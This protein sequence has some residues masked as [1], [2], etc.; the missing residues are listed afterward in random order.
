MVR[1]NPRETGID[2]QAVVMEEVPS[3]F[4]TLWSIGQVAEYLA[5]STKTLYGWRCR[6]YGPPSYRLGN[7][8]RY[9]PGE[10]MEWL[11][12]QALPS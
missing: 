5:M 2:N 8:I 4:E 7:K 6:R 10:V 12:Q 9:R 1:G 11:D 3:R